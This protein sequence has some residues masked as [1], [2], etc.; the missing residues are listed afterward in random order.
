MQLIR[1]E[2]LSTYAIPQLPI[3][4]GMF[5]LLRTCLEQGGW[6]CGFLTGASSGTAGA[7]Q[8]LKIQG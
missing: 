1:F 7:L 6:S 5:L 2:L 3:I 8:Q 4:V